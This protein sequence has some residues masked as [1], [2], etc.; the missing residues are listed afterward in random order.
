M[1]EFQTFLEKQILRLEK[2]QGAW[3]V[4]DSNVKGQNH[5]FKEMEDNKAFFCIIFLFEIIKT[6]Y[7]KDPEKILARW[8]LSY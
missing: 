6:E 1:G 7:Y 2:W 4:F 3:R 8:I 5:D